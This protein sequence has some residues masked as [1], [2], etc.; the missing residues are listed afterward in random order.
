MIYTFKQ[1]NLCEDLRQLVDE[2]DEKA[3]AA[4]HARIGGALVV[5]DDIMVD[6]NLEMTARRQQF[7]YHQLFRTECK[8]HI[9]SQIS[10]V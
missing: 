8:P 3:V 6:I 7:T 2:N 1:I 4:E 5:D 9:N 10:L